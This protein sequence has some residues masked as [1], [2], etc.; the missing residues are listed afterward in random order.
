MSKE[1]LLELVAPL[2]PAERRE[3]R[4]L[5]DERA[6]MTEEEWAQDP[7]KKFIDELEVMPPLNLPPDFGINHNH[8]IHGAPKVDD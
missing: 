3:L 7:V 2:S 4:E 6:P 1:Q 8:Y 5:L